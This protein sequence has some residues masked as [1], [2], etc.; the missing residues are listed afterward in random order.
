MLGS[1][2]GEG[3]PM[4]LMIPAMMGRPILCS[5]T[6][7]NRDLVNGG[8][9]GYLFPAGDVAAIKNAVKN[10]LENDLEKMGGASRALIFDRK[11]DADAVY[12]Q[13]L[14]LYSR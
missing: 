8:Q 13:F 4:S 14:E 12:E 10:I 5:D 1:H 11:M 9:N 7:G 6:N 3:L 2:G